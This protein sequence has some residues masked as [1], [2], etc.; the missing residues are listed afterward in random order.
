MD[1][2][3]I[4]MRLPLFDR[5]KFLLSSRGFRWVQEYPVDR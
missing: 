1:G 4:Q 3:A 5:S 2:H